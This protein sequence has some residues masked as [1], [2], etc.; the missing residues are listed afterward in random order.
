MPFA[1]ATA[2]EINGGLSLRTA[3]SSVANGG[4]VVVGDRSFIA[5]YSL[6]PGYSYIHLSDG[7]SAGQMLILMGDPANGPLGPF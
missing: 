7:L 5:V 4:T 3:L 6:T 2:L 1:P